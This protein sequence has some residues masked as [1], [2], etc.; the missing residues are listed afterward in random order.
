MGL[1][2]GTLMWPP[3]G[4]RGVSLLD[5]MQLDRMTDTGMWVWSGIVTFVVL[6]ASFFV[7]LWWHKSREER[8]KES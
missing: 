8:R 1:R 2:A 7:A 6:V 3:A 5:D 4:G